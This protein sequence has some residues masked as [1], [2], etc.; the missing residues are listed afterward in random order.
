MFELQLLISPN[1]EQQRKIYGSI[2]KKSR[3][4]TFGVCTLNW[5]L[6]MKHFVSN[7][8]DTAAMLGTDDCKQ[9]LHLVNKNKNM[10]FF[11]KIHKKHD[12]NGK[13]KTIA[14]N[15]KKPRQSLI[16]NKNS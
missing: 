4:I 16:E 15:C 13:L 8:A 2:R 11:N 5:I 3:K 1:Q 9:T 14:S 6:Y 10:L 7:D 12:N